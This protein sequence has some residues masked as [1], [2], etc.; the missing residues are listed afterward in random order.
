MSLIP[1]E[2]GRSFP[3]PHGI[4]YQRHT[5]IDFIFLTFLTLVFDLASPTASHLMQYCIVAGNITG[6]H[7]AGC[8]SR[9]SERS[10]W[11]QPKFHPLLVGKYVYHY[12]PRIILAE[13]LP[14]LILSIRN[15]SKQNW[16][17][18]F[19]LSWR[20]SCHASTCGNVPVMLVW[21]CQSTAER[22][23]PWQLIDST[24]KKFTLL[25]YSRWEMPFWF[26][27]VKIF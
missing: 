16:L 24:W 22:Y 12:P 8:R 19:R 4:W 1:H 3:R 21:S 20:L 26:T 25:L 10:C 13:S 15:R 7:L 27:L 14:W 5:S 11:L 6:R 18:Q 2:C 23:L 17:L 9:M